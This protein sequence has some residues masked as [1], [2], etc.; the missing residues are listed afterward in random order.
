MSNK[1]AIK[2]SKF[3]QK[4]QKTKLRARF[5]PSPTGF[6]HIGGARTALFNYLF[7]KRNKG[8]F[9]L[10]IED[11]DRERFMPDAPDDI[12]KNLEWLGIKW[13]E[14]PVIQ[15]R[16]LSIYKKYAEELIKKDGAYYCFCSE[17][18]LK[19]TREEQTAKKIAPMYDGKC[20]DLSKEEIK[21]KLEKGE[22]FVIRQKIPKEGAIEFID[23]IRGEI[24]F[25]NKILNDS[26]LLKSDGY[27]TYHLANVV[28][29]HLMKITHVIRA[30]EWLS[31]APKHIL[32]YKIFGWI[33]PKF[34]HIPLILGTDRSKLSK[35]RGATSMTEYRQLGYLPETLINFMVLL[36]WNPGGEKEIFNLKELI[37][38]FSLEKVQKSGAVFNIEKLDWL[39]GYYIREMTID[40]LTALCEPYL[41]SQISNLK[42]QNHNLKLK[43][44]Y[45]KRI[46][47]LEQP[48]LKKLSE[49]WEKT[50]YFFEEPQ[51]DK[52]LLRWKNMTNEEIKSALEDAKKIIKRLPTTDYRLPTIEKIFL[53]EAEKFKDRGEL[54]W[55]LRVALSGKKA[56][57]GPFEIAAI[58][59]KKEALK[60]ISNAELKV[61]SHRT[62]SNV[63]LKLQKFD[64]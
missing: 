20:R 61:D 40:K 29:D 32:L 57:P 27:P 43:T 39:N 30:E 63:V 18:R 55:P 42:S 45:L 12:K 51:Y 53:K 50:D 28:D 35:R 11:T 21:I 54:F 41:K 16:R 26:I 31:S 33:Q 25:E 17:E 62:D 44:S 4:S 34:A 24:K 10:R 8:D 6:L 19:K 7:A 52:E 9:L 60:R 14:K 37:K 23:L 5:A 59:G 22:K 15:S 2:N 36:G 13:D 56:S 38:E 64:I 1:P 46:I 3:N 49:I 58:L 48:R 47:A